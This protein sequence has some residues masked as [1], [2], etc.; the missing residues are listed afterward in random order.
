MGKRKQLL[1]AGN[2]Q[3]NKQ[4]KQ[5]NK[6]PAPGPQ[7]E[8]D[9]LEAAD[10]FE[11]GG[12]KWK[13]GDAVK[14]ARFFQRAVDTYNAGMQRYPKSFDLAY[15]K[16]HLEYQIAQDMRIAVH[17]GPSVSELLQR[18]LESHEYALALDTSNTDLIFNMAQVLS[19]LADR[20]FRAEAIT[21]S[22]KAIKLMRRCLDRQVSDYDALQAAFYAANSGDDFKPPVDAPD[23]E[24]APEPMDSEEYATV[25]EA[26]TEQD[27]LDSVTALAHMVAELLTQTPSREIAAFAEDVAYV[28]NLFKSGDLAKYLEKLDK[29]EPES[30]KTLSISLNLSTT[31]PPPKAQSPYTTTLQEVHLAHA[32]LTSAIA[33]ASYRCAK[34][35]V[36]AYYT[37]IL[38]SFNAASPSIDTS[39]ALADALA[40]FAASITTVHGAQTMDHDGGAG[41]M[42]P[43]PQTPG[44]AAQALMDNPPETAN[45]QMLWTTALHVAHYVLSSAL[46]GSLPTA[47][48]PQVFL[49]LG[50]VHWRLAGLRG[51]GRSYWAK[52]AKAAEAAGVGCVEELEEARAKE[53]IAGIMNGEKIGGLTGEETQAVGEMVEEMV[54]EGLLAG[55]DW[56]KLKE[57]VGFKGEVVV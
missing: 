32:T 1:Q 45:G 17:F 42:Y 29:S 23:V 56:V 24:P 33:S 3:Q 38:G 54:E 36:H 15:N 10:E 30:A 52:A 50:D 13:A 12:G 31:N 18:A 40:N 47:K 22:S 41:L 27:I 39:S 14:A 2:P 37:T 53:C 21:Y 51:E 20:S 44:P 28:D 25:E 11:A 46:A 55:N 43:P 8:D 6:R 19:D 57:M 7:T 16:A 34:L 49:A 5:S 26:V 48:Q 35:T 9:F 4:N